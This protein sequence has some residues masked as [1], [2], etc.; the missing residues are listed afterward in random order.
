MVSRAVI[1]RV[2]DALKMQGL[3][4]SLLA[5]EVADDVERFQQFGITSVPP[6][7]SEAIALAVGGSRSHLVVI[8]VDDR[9]FRPRNLQEGETA[10]YDKSG[11][12]VILKADGS[13]EIVPSGG[14]VNITGNLTVSGDVADA[15]GSMQEMRDTY[16]THTHPETGTTT[17]APS[18][19]MS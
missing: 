7:G 2:N 15:A 12:L 16:N 9:R 5:G 13:I 19:Q 3:Q 17:D 18:Q 11:S 4:I 14:E 1:Q 8:A 10:L 6:Q